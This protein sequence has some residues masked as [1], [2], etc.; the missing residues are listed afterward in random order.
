[1]KTWLLSALC[2]SGAAT[3]QPAPLRIATG[4]LPPYATAGRPD[5]G[6][7][8]QIV[9][10]AFELGGH[11]VSYHFL[12]WSRAQQET[13]AGLWD[14]SAYWGASDQRRRDFLLSDT[15][16]V[17]QW[18]MVHRRELDFDW[19]QLEDL[20]PWRVGVIRDYT[21]TP[22][23]WKLVNQGELRA[24]ATPDDLTGLRKLLLDRIDVLP[25]E[26]NVACDLLAK[27]FS[28]AQAAQLAAHP[29]RLTDSFTTHLLLPP[30][31]ARSP[32]LLSDFNRGLA[33]L[34]SS[35]E[36]ARILAS[37]QCPRN[38]IQAPRSAAQIPES[39]P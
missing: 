3:A 13:K 20:K 37:V 35:G 14:A 19:Q 22:A 7:A 39:R 25:I 16:L 34:R 21:Y 31:A 2:I 5:Q 33:L 9:R 1:M 24:D 32:A 17:E 27:H 28:A 26:L 38:W 4:E 11:R 36:Y 6:V 10:R 15:V 30:R 29:R 12:P 18:V 8:L 23:F